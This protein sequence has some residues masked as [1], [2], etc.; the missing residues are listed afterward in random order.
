[1]R[2]F[3]L[4]KA[5]HAVN[6]TE[7]TIQDDFM[8]DYMKIFATVLAVFCLTSITNAMD[9]SI[10]FR[11]GTILAAEISSKKPDIVIPN[12]YDSLPSYSSPMYA[13]LY[14]KFDEGRAFSLYDY[15]LSVSGKPYRC[16]AVAENSGTFNTDA[17]DLQKTDPSKIY[18]LL[19]VT[20]SLPGQQIEYTLK[21]RLFQAPVSSTTVKFL[22]LENNRFSYFSEI[23]SSGMLGISLGELL[24]KRPQ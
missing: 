1:M 15:I 23:P 17:W 8:K 3:Y 10:R 6:L 20:E 4:K 21:F 24:K 2:F 7:A 9:N 11:S 13:V 14:V 5:L 19:F 16:V 22:N 18:R 12:K